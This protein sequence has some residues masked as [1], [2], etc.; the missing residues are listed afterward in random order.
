VTYDNTGKAVGPTIS[1]GVLDL[2]DYPVTPSTL[3]NPIGVV[4]PVTITPVP[5]PG[6][7]A[8]AASAAAVL[9]ATMIR[10]RRI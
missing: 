4:E 7:V 6:T 10:R 8:L 9:A 3:L 5:E 2:E 1:T